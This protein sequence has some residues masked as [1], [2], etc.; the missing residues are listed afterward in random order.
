MKQYTAQSTSFLLSQHHYESSDGLLEKYSAK[1]MDIG[2][3]IEFEYSDMVYLGLG[4][5]NGYGSA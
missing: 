2:E 5:H 3:Q 1:L 4:M